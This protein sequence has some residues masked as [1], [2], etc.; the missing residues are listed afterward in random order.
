MLESGFLQH[1]RT[2]NIAFCG[3]EKPL[4]DF[5]IGTVHFVPLCGID[6]NAYSLSQG[7]TVFSL[8]GQIVRIFGF[9]SH[10]CSRKAATDNTYIIKWTELRSNEQSFTKA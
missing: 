3:L 9:A 1:V 6:L 5:N 8:K 10:S 7:L 2:E 4:K